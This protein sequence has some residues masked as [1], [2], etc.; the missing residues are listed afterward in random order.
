VA[1]RPSQL[2]LDSAGLNALQLSQNW[3]INNMKKTKRPDEYVLQP[4]FAYE[5]RVS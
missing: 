3:A 4:I 2:N 5:R 1:G